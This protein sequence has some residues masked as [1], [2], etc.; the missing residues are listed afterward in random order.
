[1]NSQVE[2]EREHHQKMLIENSNLQRQLQELQ[3]LFLS[4]I[5]SVSG[6]A[7]YTVPHLY[8]LYIIPYL[9]CTACTSYCTSFVSLVYHIAPSFTACT[10][11]FT[12][13]VLLVHHT[14]PHLYRLYI[15]LYIPHFYRLYI[16]LYLIYTACIS[17]CNSS[18]PL[19]YHTVPHFYRLYITLYLICIACT[20]HY[21]SFVSLVYHTVTSFTPCISYCTSFKLPM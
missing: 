13:F 9:I 17:Y 19:V 2:N 16:I 6:L 8:R 18:L 14:A 7:H 12:S 10:S 4:L 3:V 15:T 11:C 5:W 21:T 20:S 1:M